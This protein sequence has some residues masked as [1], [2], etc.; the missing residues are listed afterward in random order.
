MHGSFGHLI[1]NMWSLFSF[2]ED[3]HRRLGRY[4]FLAFY[5]SS[6]MVGNL[7]SVLLRMMNRSN[8]S[9]SYGSS[10]A[11]YGI[12]TLF[13]LFNPD[14]STSF[15]MIPF[16]QIPAQLFLS[17]VLIVDS[18]GAFGQLTNQFIL[19][20]HVDHL[21]HLGGAAF[22]LFVYLL[23]TRNQSKLSSNSKSDS[24]NDNQR[25]WGNGKIGSIGKQS[26]DE[27]KEEK[28]KFPGT[29]RTLKD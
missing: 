2:G 9:V 29:G 28:E 19:F 13:A 22:G 10:G 21:A 26:N 20:E 4:R 12:M 25:F 16:I 5:I 7:F 14:V 24:N 3:I 27:K 1:M 11:I 8:S 18:F 6:G 17:L 23:L 15:W